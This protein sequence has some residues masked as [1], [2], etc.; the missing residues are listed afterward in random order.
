MF[1]KIIITFLI[2]IITINLVPEIAYAVEAKTGLKIITIKSY[3]KENNNE[4]DVVIP[5]IIIDNSINNKLNND[6]NYW[7]EKIVNDFFK[8]NNASNHK[9][10]QVSYNIIKNDSNWLTIKLN[11]LE[12][13][14]SSYNY[15]KYY[16][17][18]IKSKR[19][20]IL[21]DLFKS[22]N[23]KKVMEDEIIKQIKNENS[24]DYLIENIKIK[25]DQNF[26]FNSNDNIVIVFDQ[27]EI[28][29][30]SIGAPEYEINKKLYENYLK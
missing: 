27:Y 16:H 7:T 26:Y 4:L 13:M 22:S 19:Q 15:F 17:V 6:I 8:E 20:V 14:A 23:Y 21:N 5:N 11:V 3:F 18:D 9:Y 1:K 29:P 12:I 24:K 10:V 28:G 2:A 30:G 25:D